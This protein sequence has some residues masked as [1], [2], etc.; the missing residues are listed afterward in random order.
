MKTIMSYLPVFQGFYGT[1]FE[2]NEESEIEDG[3]NYDDY[4]WDYA[5]YNERVAK[6]CVGVI[7]NELKQFDLTI[8]FKAVYSPREYNFSN[9]EINV[10]YTLKRGSFKKIVNYLK[11]NKEEFAIYL[12]ETFKSRDGFH[13]FFEHDLKTWFDEYLKLSYDKIETVFGAVLEFI[14]SNEGFN[15]EDLADLVSGDMFIFGELKETV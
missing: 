6:A 11:E 12:E 5:A 13:S 4:N 7:E 14:L 8:D 10:L 15:A 3:K 1:L 9:D 2:A